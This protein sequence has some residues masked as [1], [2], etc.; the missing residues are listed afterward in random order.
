MENL[1]SHV[2]DFHVVD[3]QRRFLTD[4]RNKRYQKLLSLATESVKRQ[5]K[6]Q[7]HNYSVLDISVQNNLSIRLIFEMQIIIIIKRNWHIA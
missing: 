7:K 2:I 1:A 3:S 4:L 5:I 6:S